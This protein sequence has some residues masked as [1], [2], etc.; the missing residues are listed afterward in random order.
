[1]VLSEESYDWFRTSGEQ[2]RAA[3]ASPHRSP[4]RQGILWLVKRLS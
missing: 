2:H 4:L 1:M 3:H